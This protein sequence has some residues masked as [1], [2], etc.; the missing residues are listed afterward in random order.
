MNETRTV[1]KI[2][3]K[4]VEGRRGRGR[5]RLKRI[6][7]EEEDLGNMGIKRWRIRATDRAEWASIIKEAKAKLKGP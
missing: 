1:K 4:K 7:D 6:D 3:E 2:C 5:S